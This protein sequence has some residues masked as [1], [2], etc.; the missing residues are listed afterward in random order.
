M[1]IERVA[2]IGLGLIGGSL[3][4]AWKKNRPEL[5]IAGYDAPDVLNT[6]LRRG[7]ID[8]AYSDDLTGAV[9]NADVVVLAVPLTTMLRLMGELAPG[10]KPGAVVT[11]VGSVKMPVIRHAQE[12]LPPEAAFIGGHPMAGAE[13]GGIGNA[14]PFLF[15]NATYVLCPADNRSTDSIQADHADFVDLIRATGARLL[16]LE[17]ERHDR[18]ASV[19]SHLPQLLA[20][21]LMNFAAEH[22]AADD[23]FL[24]L[25]A[26]G[27]RDM[28]RI[29]SSPF[30]IW[31]DIL[32]ANEGSILDALGG[33]A[34]ELQK[35]RNRLIE[36]DLDNLQ[37][38]FDAARTIRNT[39]PKNTKGFLY[40]LA[41]AYV[42]AEDRPGEL[43]AIT[44]T[45]V[46]AELNIK[47]IELL[48]IREGTGGAFRLSFADEPTADAAV[49]ALRTA[50][51][52]AYRL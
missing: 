24:R 18:I 35:M 8:T 30:D 43:L 2:L 36:E 39:I 4:L 15:E 10:L 1:P 22:N 26:G 19:V 50:S 20:V 46:E 25:A 27:F 3:G 11:D 16:A 23:A 48:K 40:P 45:L 38:R 6:A 42:Y 13:R 51:F 34:A 14:D 17:P 33:F 41:D 12:V 32:I 47:D 52:T 7:A 5:H 9:Q 31:R 49:A 21:T 29:A 28:T 44:R 37:E